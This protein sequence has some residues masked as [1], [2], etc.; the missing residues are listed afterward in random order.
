MALVEQREAYRFPTNLEAD[1]RMSGRTWPT[2]LRNVSTAGCMIAIPE[3]GLSDGWMMRLWIPGLPVLDAE[4]VWQRS[5]HAGLQF[6]V[7]RQPTALEQLGFRLPEP[8]QSPRAEPVAELGG[9]HARLVK[10]APP[11]EGLRAGTA[12]EVR[13][14]MQTVA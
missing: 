13:S 2:R 3:E 9:L 8:R 12:G 14:S 1:C 6:L 7:A 11:D 10:R 5:G 4:I